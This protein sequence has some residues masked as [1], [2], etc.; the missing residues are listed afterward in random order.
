MALRRLYP[1]RCE[2]RAARRDNLAFWAPCR[3]AWQDHGSLVESRC[4]VPVVVPYQ[5]A[6]TDHRRRH[7]QQIHDRHRTQQQ[8]AAA[9]AQRPQRHGSG[10]LAHGTKIQTAIAQRVVEVFQAPA[11]TPPAAATAARRPDSRPAPTAADPAARPA[12]GS[13]QLAQ[14]VQRRLCGLTQPAAGRRRDIPAHAARQDHVERRP[15]QVRQRR[16]GVHEHQQ[17]PQTRTAARPETPASPAS[18]AAHPAASARPP[19][20]A[21]QPT[22]CRLRT[23]A[24]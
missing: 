20:R 23:A 10:R 24:R 16:E 14:F 17:Q 22:R 15:D 2:E 8:H 3:D 12:P 19:P 13:S 4:S 11:A 9:K 1:R 18:P 21:R 6:G 5:Q 7:Q